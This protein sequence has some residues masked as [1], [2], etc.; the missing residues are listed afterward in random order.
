MNFLATW[1]C[2]WCKE[3]QHT[4]DFIYDEMLFLVMHSWLC[5]KELGQPPSILGPENLENFGCSEVENND[6][7]QYL[8]ER[9]TWDGG[10]HGSFADRLLVYWLRSFHTLLPRC[11]AVGT[12]RCQGCTLDEKLSCWVT[13]VTWPFRRS[14]VAWGD[15][16]CI[17]CSLFWHEGV[18]IS[19]VWAWWLD[20]SPN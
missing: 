14:W 1:L 17:W 15:W 20:W 16:N 8:K 2:L 7:L 3:I 13:D 5:Q 11:M 9:F 10:G 4:L 12:P 18:H 19:C 6:V